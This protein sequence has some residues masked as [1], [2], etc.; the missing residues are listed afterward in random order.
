MTGGHSI[1]DFI[2]EVDC[3]YK[4]ERYSVRDN[5]AVLRHPGNSVRARSADNTWT[6]GRPNA[7]TGYCEVCSVRVHQIVAMAFHGERPSTGHVIDHV[8]TN[9]CNNRPENL[10]YVTRLENILLNPITATRISYICGSVEAFLANPAEF[11]DA[12]RDPNY[13]WMTT[14][15]A[16]EAKTSYERMMKWAAGGKVS[17]KVA[18]SGTLDRWIF[19]RG[20]GQDV[21]LYEEFQQPD[22]TPSLT[23][24]AAQ[25]DWKTPSEFPCC[26]QEFTEPI[27][28]YVESL[29]EGKV[30]CRNQWYTSIVVKHAVLDGGES[31]YVMSENADESGAIKPWVLAEITFEQGQFVHINRRNFFSREGAEKQYILAQGLEWTGEDSIDDYC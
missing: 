10:R 27:T 7:K 22:P 24:N 21:E 12:F 2:R 29:K 5:G 19:S 31:I 26:P 16:E 14:V 6:F 25:R 18:G 17:G 8:D 15:S 4:N 30:F 11:R 28:A 3:I 13:T 1:E 23:A 9:R 20:N